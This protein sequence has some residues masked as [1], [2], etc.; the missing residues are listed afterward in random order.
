MSLS[1]L[2]PTPLL[3]EAEEA[4]GRLGGSLVSH[5]AWD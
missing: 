3:W 2:A 5:T 4:V 1:S